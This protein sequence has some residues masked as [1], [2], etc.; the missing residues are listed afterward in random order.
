MLDNYD[1]HTKTEGLQ[2]MLDL[3][4]TVFLKEI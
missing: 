4:R 3:E 2:I 1:T